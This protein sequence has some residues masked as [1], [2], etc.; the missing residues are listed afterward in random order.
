MNSHS[1]KHLKQRKTP[2]K[3]KKNTSKLSKKRKD[4]IAKQ[5]DIENKYKHITNTND[6]SYDC[7]EDYHT[8]CDASY[9]LKD[10]KDLYTDKGLDDWEEHFSKKYYNINEFDKDKIETLEIIKDFIKELSTYFIQEETCVIKRIEYKYNCI[11]KHKRN[12]GHDDAILYSE[13]YAELSM[14]LII[15]VLELYKTIKQNIKNR[16]KLEDDRRKLEDD[17][18]E[19]IDNIKDD[20]LKKYQLKENKI[21]IRM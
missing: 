15:K 10:I 9:F 13:F 7:S 16:R 4:Y 2:N 20:L 3:S 21:I 12:K 19:H 1:K 11:P 8:Y 18:Y 6:N 5:P 17:E 14:E